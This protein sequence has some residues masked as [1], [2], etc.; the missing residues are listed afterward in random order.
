MG[1]EERKSQARNKEKDYPMMVA[2]ERHCIWQGWKRAFILG[3]K[4]KI[5]VLASKSV[6]KNDLQIWSISTDFQK[7]VPF[8]FDRTISDNY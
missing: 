3:K 2:G 7:Q 4:K 8:T 1:R 6:R 5:E